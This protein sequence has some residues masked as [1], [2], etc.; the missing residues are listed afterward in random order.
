[1]AHT[2]LR[3]GGVALVGKASPLGAQ[4]AQHRNG[5]GFSGSGAP[6]FGFGLADPAPKG[7]G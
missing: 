7:Q 4:I 5:S 6:I 2:A 1:M 3:V